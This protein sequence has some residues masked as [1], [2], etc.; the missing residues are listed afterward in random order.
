MKKILGMYK[1]T[2]YEETMIVNSLYANADRLDTF[3]KK[4]AKFC[5]DLAYKLQ[6]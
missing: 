3:D 4:N 6:T 5:K 2:D 1:F